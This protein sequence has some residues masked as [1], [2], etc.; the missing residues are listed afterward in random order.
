MLGVFMLAHLTFALRLLRK[1]PGYTLAVVVTLAIGIGANTTVFSFADSLLLRPPAFPEI[2]R[3]LAISGSVIQREAGGDHQPSGVAPADF[4]DWRQETTSFVA[5]AAWSGWM[6]DLSGEGNPERLPGCLVTANFFATLGVRPERGTVFSADSNEPGAGNQVMLSHGLW[7]RRFG[8]DTNVVGQVIQIARSPYVVV[9]I[10]PDAAQ[11]PP[12][13]ELWAPLTLD[14]SAWAERESHYLRAVGRLKAGASASQALA[15]LRTVAGRLAIEYPRSHG[16]RSVHVRPLREQLM[17]GDLAIVGLAGG[18]TLFVLMLVCAN[19]ANLQLAHGLARR[20][21][22]AIRA[23]LGANR[24]RLIGQLLTESGMLGLV[25]GALGVLLAS[26]AI[27]LVKA[28]L[29]TEFALPA[30]SIETV[31]LNLRALGFT[32]GLSLLV[33]MLTGL[34]PA[35]SAVQPDVINA[36]KEGGRQATGDRRRQGLRRVLVVSEIAFA[37]VL[38]TGAGIFLQAFLLAVR[39]EPGM[40]LEGVVALQIMPAGEQYS[41]RGHVL[42]FKEQAVQEL[43]AIPGVK[44]LAV[45]DSLPVGHTRRQ[46]VEPDRAG[47]PLTSGLAPVTCQSVGPGYFELLQIPLRGGRGFEE[48]D[49]PTS[50]RVAVVSETLAKRVFPG[51]DPI[52]GRLRLAAPGVE[53]PWLTVVGVVGDVKQDPWGSEPKALYLSVD[54]ESP[55]TYAFLLRT[56]SSPESLIPEVRKRMRALD[57]HQPLL[58]LDTLLESVRRGL[59]AIPMLAPILGALG[60]LALGLCALGIYSVMAQTVLAR[61]PEIGVRLALGATQ[62]T[63]FRLVLGGGLRLAGWGLGIGLPL[64]LGLGWGLASQIFEVGAMVHLQL[65]LLGAVLFAIGSMALAACWLPAR[66]AMRVDPMVALRSE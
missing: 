26:W 53:N 59:G 46:M 28:R 45:A 8:G 10:M 48:S 31:T 1:N 5:M 39:F 29:A 64:A 65:L 62:G 11:Y 27:Q 55:M 17:L 21:E 52:G 56:A 49:G 22:L 20:H 42:A 40:E 24:R 25:G 7:Q 50:L 38:L 23:A 4:N 14:A 34:V 13:V 33:G 60:L 15:E 9:G 18:A 54:Q 61:T 2:G 51:V 19:V 3:L 32:V 37:L 43:A 58:S 66:R 41:A 57:P 35:L 30:A 16:T 36:L 6:A 47:S 63:V 12:G 44:A